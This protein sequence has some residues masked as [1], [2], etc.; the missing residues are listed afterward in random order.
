MKACGMTHA[1][2]ADTATNEA[3]G[4]APWYEIDDHVV[5]KRICQ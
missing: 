3:C 2:V 5:D 1:T 4:L